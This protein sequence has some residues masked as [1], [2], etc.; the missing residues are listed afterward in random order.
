LKL[1]EKHISDLREANKHIE[2][3][4]LCLEVMR[5]YNK[6]MRKKKISKK[7]NMPINKVKLI[8]ELDLG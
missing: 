8:L 5:L 2:R 7:L 6:G 3:L 1:N 4:S